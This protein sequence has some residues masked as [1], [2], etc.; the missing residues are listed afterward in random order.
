M[1]TP[2]PV[3]PGRPARVAEGLPTVG[4]RAHPGA[5]TRL[6]DPRRP[7][8][9]G[10][11]E[12]RIL[13]NLR[14]DVAILGWLLV[15][16]GV[17][18]LPAV[19]LAAA[20]GESPAIPLAHSSALAMIFGFCIALSSRTSDRR[21]RPRDGYFVVTGGWFLACFFGAMPYLFS[22]ALGPADALFESTSGFTTTGSTVLTAIEST[23]RSLLLWRSMTQWLGG[24][25]IILFAIAV[26][27]LLGIGGMKLFQAEVPG[28]V[29]D[30]LTPRIADTARRLWLVYAGLTAVAGCA[31]WLAGM[32]A[33]D[34]LC[35]ALTTL[36]TGGFST[37]GGSV[38]AFASPAIEWIVIAFM[39][40]AGMNFVLLWR[41]LSLRWGGRLRRDAELRL[42]VGLLVLSVAAAAV[43]LWGADGEGDPLR[44]AAFQVVSLATTTGFIT[45]DYELW[46]PLLHFGVLVFLVVGAMAGSTGGG[47]KSLHLLLAWRKLRSVLELSTHRHV[48]LPV[49]YRGRPVPDEVVTGVFAFLT[50]YLFI[51]GLAA[52]VVAAAGFDLLT[53]LTAALTAIGNVGPGLGEVG[54]RDDFAAFPASV[55]LSLALCMVA[56]RLEIITL[57]VVLSPRFWRR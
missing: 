22:G 8:W 25:G 30:K 57:L 45:A 49:S 28:P 24:M 32:D 35:H 11:R 50:A 26:L 41:L 51:V 47:I 33:F 44:A 12:E 40:L 37:R 20:A 43:V 34:A 46:P 31:L 16:V 27:P 48:L 13:V 36:S 2:S 19:I 29:A 17:F 38:G 10:P 21:M 6:F 5:F 42:Y 7:M 39:V 14:L 4:G 15:G 3:G 52:A 18:Q 54:P 23:P 1:A 56:G 9:W 53:A 55:K